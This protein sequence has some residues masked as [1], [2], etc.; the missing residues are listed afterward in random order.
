VINNIG[1][2]AGG[3]SLL[4]ISFRRFVTMIKQSGHASIRPA[5]NK[6]NDIHQEIDVITVFPRSRPKK[7]I[8]GIVFIT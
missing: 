8:T 7:D 6:K 3:D 5:G 2:S 1:E 4:S